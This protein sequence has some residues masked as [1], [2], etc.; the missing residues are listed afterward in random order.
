MKH[1]GQLKSSSAKVV[2][3]N[4]TLPGDGLS[5][6]VVNKDA[7]RPF[8]ED[9]IMDLLQSPEGQ[10]AF[11]FAHVLGRHKM[12]LADSN[13]PAEQSVGT[14]IQ[15]ISALE[16][17]HLKGLLLKQATENVLVITPGE[18][19]I[20]LDKLNEMIAEQKGVKVDGLAIQADTTSSGDSGKAQAKLVLNRAD[21]LEKQMLAM[22]ENAYQLDPETR[23][24]KGR[25]KK[26]SE[27]E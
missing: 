7:L 6:L 19:A 17:F 24:R 18:D 4:R 3:I 21:K 22:R 23:P 14:S 13:N 15:G 26:N 8:E 12:P 16:H 1:L 5:C 20:Q 2:I 10:K 27:D 25:P 9:L 11:E